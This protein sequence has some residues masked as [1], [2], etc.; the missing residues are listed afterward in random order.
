MIHVMHKGLQSSNCTLS[1]A[2]ALTDSLKAHFVSKRQA[3]SWNDV[4]KSVKQFCLDNNITVPEENTD[5]QIH[6]PAGP[7]PKRNRVSNP[8]NSLDG[9]LITSTLGQRETTHEETAECPGYQ[10]KLYYPVLDTLI[11]EPERR[12]S[13]ESMELAR[14][15]ACAAVLTCDGNGIDLLLQKYTPALKVN[16]LLLAAEMKLVKASADAPIS[17]EHLKKAVKNPS[18]SLKSFTVSS[19]SADW[20]IY[21]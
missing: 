20:V 10:Q 6:V 13:D 15:A 7:A 19:H 14:L 21:L 3:D 1:E 16:P 9:F 18:K 8:P 12:F 2:A 4:W 11:N 17:M 5:R